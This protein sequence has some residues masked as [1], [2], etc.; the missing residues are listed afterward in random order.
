MKIIFLD[1]DGVLRTLRYDR[2]SNHARCER[3][4]TEQTRG[5]RCGYPCF[6]PE[7]VCNLNLLVSQTHASIVVSST[8]REFFDDNDWMR[9][10]FR[11]QRVDGPIVGPTPVLTGI[12]QQRG[13]EI[14]AWLEPIGDLVKSFV[15]L[16][17]EDHQWPDELRK[18]WIHTD[19]ELGLGMK[20]V[21]RAVEMLNE[22]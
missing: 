8:W 9:C 15:I 17:D 4:I 5:S 3:W 1:V 20:H 10:M 6:D 22:S 14:K 7:A 11:G 2:A 18:R 13:D 19:Y 12:N 21:R 16:D